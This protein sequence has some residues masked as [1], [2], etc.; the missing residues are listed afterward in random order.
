MARQG[1][2]G[3]HPDKLDVARS[4]TGLIV[5]DRFMARIEPAAEDPGAPAMRP[6]EKADLD[7]D[8]QR[9]SD[10]GDI[11]ERTVGEVSKEPAEGQG[12]TGMQRDQ[13][14][15]ADRDGGGQKNRCLPTTSSPEA[16][17]IAGPAAQIVIKQERRPTGSHPRQFCHWPQGAAAVG[18]RRNMACPDRARR[19]ADR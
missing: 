12:C 2:G 11:G 5:I 18:V 7:G 4:P 14:Q 17:P 8:E 9:K 6:S 16:R 15:N 10:R 19:G 13:A 1:R 3:Y